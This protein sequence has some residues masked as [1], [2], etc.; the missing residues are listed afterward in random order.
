MS[1]SHVVRMDDYRNRRTE[2]LHRALTLSGWR[3]SE[4][5]RTSLLTRALQITGADRALSFWVDEYDGGAIHLDRVVD[6]ASDPPRRAVP[7]GLLERAYDHGFPGLIDTPDGQ[8]A[9]AL[10]FPEAPNSS[11]LLSVGSDGAQ[12]WFVLVDGLTPRARLDVR[13]REQL[14]FL[15]GELS[16]LLLREEH[17]RWQGVTGTFER[18]RDEAFAGW[19]VLGDLAEGTLTEEDRPRVNVRFL[20]ARLVKTF[21]DE[22]LYIERAG[23]SDQVEQVRAELQDV[24]GMEDE[25]PALERVL[26]SLQRS[27]VA[28]LGQATLALADH[29]WTCRHLHA[30]RDLYLSAHQ[31][32]VHNANADAAIQSAWGLGRASR[33]AT[34]WDGAFRWYRIAA[35]LSKALGSQHQY[36]RV[37]DGLANAY[38]DR[39]NLP[40]ARVVLA[41]AL[42]VANA[43]RDAELRAT[44]FHNL[45]TVEKQAGESSRAIVYGWE[46]VQAQPDPVAR[47]WALVDLGSV[48]MEAG[49][50]DDAEQTLA[51]ALREDLDLSAHVMAL[52][53]MS[54]I[55]ALRGNRSEFTRHCATLEEIGWH[56]APAIVRGQVILD[57]GVSWAR[58]GEPAKAR[59]IL[60]WA[61]SFGETQRVAK[62]TLDAD[63]ALTSLDEGALA[64]DAAQKSRAAQVSGDHR[65]AEVRR[66]LGMV[67]AAGAAT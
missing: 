12:S 60:E 19:G 64:D 18:T 21:L 33:T 22:G 53:T 54:Q 11:V 62:I 27:D 43:E 55:A 6:L 67:A 61:L 34:D 28:G 37:L 57:R 15:A 66:H 32:A 42:D 31:F 49:Q 51:L 35:D 50:L 36:G 3:T 59:D 52:S 7:E 39:G 13:Q 40:K 4:Q 14:M 29:Y 25:A 26:D 1:T 20:T 41:E 47:T 63:T 17:S 46:A 38:R 8:R 30:A 24:P 9:G 16:T 23:L 2:R 58:L 45:M 48:F 44:V 56:Q 65:V 10:L 5:A